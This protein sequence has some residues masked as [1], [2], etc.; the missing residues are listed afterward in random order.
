MSISSKT[1]D[2]IYLTII[3]FATIIVLVLSCIAIN[4]W[5]ITKGYEE[6]N[7]YGGSETHFKSDTN[8]VVSWGTVITKVVGKNTTTELYYPAINKYIGF[9][10]LS[11]VKSWSAGITSA[12]TVT[13]LLNDDLSKGITTTYPEIWIWWVLFVIVIIVICVEIY[14]IY[15]WIYEQCMERKHQRN[16]GERSIV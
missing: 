12:G 9:E 15:T 16:I 2:C 6:Y 3:V 7:C 1:E 10:K 13:C 11:A 8:G 14:F 5:I 4:D